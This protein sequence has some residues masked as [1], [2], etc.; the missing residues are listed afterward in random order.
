[1]SQQINHLTYLINKL[2]SE[3]ADKDNQ[4][5]GSIKNSDG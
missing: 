1:M 2:K 4:I 3:I 5:A